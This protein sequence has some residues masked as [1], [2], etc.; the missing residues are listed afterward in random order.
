MAKTFRKTS[1]YHATFYIKSNTNTETN[2]RFKISYKGQI[3][4]KIKNFFIFFI[5]NSKKLPV[6]GLL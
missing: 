4:Q 6:K 5:Y 3:E 1:I 2:K